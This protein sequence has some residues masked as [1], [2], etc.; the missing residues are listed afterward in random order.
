LA[1]IFECDPDKAEL[2]ARKHGVTFDEATTVFGDPLV[3]AH[4]PWQ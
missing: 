2:N 4:G 1:Y 3:S